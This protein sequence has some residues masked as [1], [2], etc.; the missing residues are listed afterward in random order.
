MTITNDDII[1]VAMDNINVVTNFMQEHSQFIL[2]A[3]VNLVYKNYNIILGDIVE[4][5]FIRSDKFTSEYALQIYNNLRCVCYNSGQQAEN[6]ISQQ[7]KRAY[8]I[9]NTLST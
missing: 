2:P 8:I 9:S 3:N 5:R 7:L 1:K 6:A 4:L